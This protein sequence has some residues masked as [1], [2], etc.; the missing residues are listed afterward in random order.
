MTIRRRRMTLQSGQRGLTEARTFMFVFAFL[1]QPTSLQH[2]TKNAKN[3][4]DTVPT[5]ARKA[6]KDEMQNAL[7]HRFSSSG[8]AAASIPRVSRS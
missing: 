3:A 7:P 1:S 6:L 2:Q 5:C 4:N 8:R